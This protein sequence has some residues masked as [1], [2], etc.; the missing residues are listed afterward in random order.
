MFTMAV[1]D[2]YL[3]VNP[4][5]DVKTP[6]VAGQRAIKIVTREQY[7]RVRDC[8]PTKPAR[9]FSTLMVSSGMRFC[10]AVGLHPADL[11]FDNCVLE[12]A[13][14]VVKVSRKHHPQGK[15]FLV[16]EYTKNGGSRRIKLDRPVV[17]LVRDY[18]AD[19]EIGPSDVIFPAELIVPPRAT[20]PGLSE[21]EIKAL[22]FTGPVR[23]RVYAHGTMGGYVTAKC[24]CVGCRQW[25][26]E[27]GRE[28]MRERRAAASTSGAPRRRWEKSGDA[29]EPYLDEI[30]WNRIWAAAVS[31]SGI[32]FK[33]TAYQVRHTH[34]SWLID[35]GES[36]K[37]VMH[38]L[39][40]SDLR[41]TARYVHVLDEFGE[42]AAMRF[43][44]LL[45]PVA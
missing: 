5:H 26:R 29:D 36:P 16:R 33:P 37:S 15:T 12:I 21:A 18:V 3:D 9:V 44:G 2:T 13:R 20:T 45:P 34:A 1:G 32:P 41:T 4:F 31:A 8:L 40:Q 35:A 30:T 42:S 10:E 7:V 38:R 11:D 22:G 17:E 28:R 27:Y 43:E 39:G 19:H 25:A 23:G 14:S 24:R 6:K